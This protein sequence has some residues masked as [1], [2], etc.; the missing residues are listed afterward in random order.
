MFIGAGITVS[1]SVTGFRAITGGLMICH[2]AL[3]TA[4]QLLKITITTVVAENLGDDYADELDTNLPDTTVGM[5]FYLLGW[6]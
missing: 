4:T 2:E 6:V 3:N 1:T 5:I